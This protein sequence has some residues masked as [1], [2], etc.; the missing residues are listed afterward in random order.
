MG[1]DSGDKTEE[2]TPHK[3]REARKKGQIA[4]K[5]LEVRLKM[6]E[7]SGKLNMPVISGIIIGNDNT[8][9]Q[10]KATI[11]KICEHQLKYKNIHTL[12]IQSE[13]LLTTGKPT[14]KSDNLMLKAIEY[15]KST[16]VDITISTPPIH[17]LNIGNFIDIGIRDFGSI[18]INPEL[19]FPKIEPVNFKELEEI[20]EKKV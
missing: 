14:K 13:A 2:P 5:Y 4:K 19:L 8:E 9:S 15:I 17:T 3:I 18:P 20:V 7:W 12:S 16:G 1:E 10:T 6:L 11:D